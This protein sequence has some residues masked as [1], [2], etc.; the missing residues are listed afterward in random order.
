MNPFFLH[1][2]FP[3]SLLKRNQKTC[4]GPFRVP[5]AQLPHYEISSQPSVFYEPEVNF[6]L[7]A[8]LK[9]LLAT[10][11]FFGLY[12]RLWRLYGALEPLW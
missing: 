11:N 5:E 6:I 3:T 9:I 7:L 10:S 4:S 8:F 1:N 2:F 12:A